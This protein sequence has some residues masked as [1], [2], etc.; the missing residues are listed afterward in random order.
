MTPDKYWDPKRGSKFNGKTY[1]ENIKNSSQNTQCYNLW[2]YY[3]SIC[4]KCRFEIVKSITLG[5]KLG[6]FK[7]K[8]FGFLLGPS[9]FLLGLL[10]SFESIFVNLCT[11]IQASSDSELYKLWSLTK[12]WSPNGFQV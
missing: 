7:L 5:A 2:Y 12:Y 11:V 4:S 10:G 9:G 1:G 8:S 3:A 6:L